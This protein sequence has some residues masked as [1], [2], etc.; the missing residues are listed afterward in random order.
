M[1][2]VR[3]LSLIISMIVIAVSAPTAYAQNYDHADWQN[4]WVFGINKLPARNTTWPCPDA[5]SAWK[6]NY[7][8]SPWL[9]SLNGSWSFNWVAEPNSRPKDFFSPTFDASKWKKITVPSCWELEGLKIDPVGQ[10]NYGVP[11]Y[12][13]SNYPFSVKRW[14]FVMDEPNKTYT[15]YKQRNP[16]GSY[17]R[18]F[19][20]PANWG[21]GRTIIHFAGVY[22]AFYLWI[23][24]HKVGYSENSRLPAEF[25]ITKYLKSKNIAK[26]AA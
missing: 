14:P 19:N 4:Q 9:L 13:N 20:V 7:D 22:S 17:R 16:V 21:H 8:Y 25:D 24:G 3:I 10:N 26:N 11:I 6:S 23:N 12:T 1:N 15:A 2:K 18:L 5:K